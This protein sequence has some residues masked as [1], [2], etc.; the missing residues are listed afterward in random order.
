[1]HVSLFSQ[2]LSIQR[3]GSL[4]SSWLP[5]HLQTI[6]EDATAPQEPGCPF[7]GTS[8]GREVKPL[9]W[10]GDDSQNKRGCPLSVQ[11]IYPHLHEKELFHM[12]SLQTEATHYPPKSV[13]VPECDLSDTLPLLDV[14][15]EQKLPTQVCPS[16]F[17]L[18][19]GR[20]SR[21][22]YMSNKCSTLSHIPNKHSFSL[23]PD[24][25]LKTFLNWFL[26]FFV[27]FC[28]LRHF[29]A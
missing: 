28:F 14:C 12:H 5:P 3:L 21:S 29:S 1:M 19:R 10:A 26:F 9:R 4:H 16:L 18:L 20:E 2:L 23:N 22:L 13:S 24:L 17:L 25:F 7:K 6:V 27:L 11:E 8:R 15:R